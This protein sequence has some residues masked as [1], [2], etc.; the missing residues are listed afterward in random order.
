MELHFDSRLYVLAVWL[1]FYV[2]AEAGREKLGFFVEKMFR[3]LDF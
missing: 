1:N 2:N 3:L